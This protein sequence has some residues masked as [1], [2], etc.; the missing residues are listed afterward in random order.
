MGSIIP[1]A[2]HC[3]SLSELFG[4][5]K[6]IGDVRGTASS[7]IYCRVV[8]W[9]EDGCFLRLMAA[10]VKCCGKDG[11]RIKKHGKRFENFAFFFFPAPFASPS[12]Q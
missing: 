4:D 10:I 12:S 3:K 11:L 8:L 5:K 1:S 7:S 6:D 9:A 2:S